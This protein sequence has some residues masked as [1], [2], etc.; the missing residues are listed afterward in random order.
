M[1]TSKKVSNMSSVD[2]V[3][4]RDFIAIVDSSDTTAGPSGTTKK[5][6]IQQIMRADSMVTTS[7]SGSFNFD[8]SSGIM[9]THILTGNLSPTVSNF[10]IGDVLKLKLK[11]DSTGSRTVTW[12]STINWA[13]GSAPTLTTTGNKS[14]WIV[15][16]CTGSGTYDGGVAMANV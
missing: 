9:R 11:Q 1:T 4:R 10:N 15:I 5:A 2:I 7:G 12:F 6:S 13:G 3:S 14:D 8:L 16:V